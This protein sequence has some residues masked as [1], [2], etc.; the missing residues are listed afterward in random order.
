VLKVAG[1]P[2]ATRTLVSVTTPA[3]QYRSAAHV[4]PAKA[5]CPSESKIRAFSPNAAFAKST[6]PWPK[7]ETKVSCNAV[8]RI[9]VF[10]VP[11]RV[12]HQLPRL[13]KENS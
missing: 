4:L 5:V 3:A 10:T 6:V 11:I 13:T 9:N 12:G 7:L 2:N 8:M 1:C